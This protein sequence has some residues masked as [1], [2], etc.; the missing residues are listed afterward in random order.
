VG[1]V[2]VEDMV[3]KLRDEIGQTSAESIEIESGNYTTE[4]PGWFDE[5]N[6]AQT[7]DI[8]EMLNAGE[9]PVHEVLQAIKNWKTMRF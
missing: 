3:S 8:R 2:K 4:K 6:V 9:Q 5:N 7:I 1:G